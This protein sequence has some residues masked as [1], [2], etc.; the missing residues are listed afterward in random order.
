MRDFQD[1]QSFYKM[2]EQPE[3]AAAQEQADEPAA[4]FNMEEAE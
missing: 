3:A 4:A 2:S 1:L